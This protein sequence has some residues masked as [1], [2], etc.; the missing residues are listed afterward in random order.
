[1]TTSC[2]SSSTILNSMEPS[3]SPARKPTHIGRSAHKSGLVY[4]IQNKRTSSA[5]PG[6]LYIKPVLAL[7]FHI[8]QVSR[9]PFPTFKMRIR[10]LHGFHY[11]QISRFNRDNTRFGNMMR[12]APF[13]VLWRLDACPSVSL[14]LE[15][16]IWI[17]SSVDS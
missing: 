3:S 8:R 12:H 1:V 16:P 11:T 6:A 14:E 13:S 2:T 10:H 4:R 5:H 15:P 9:E 7:L 17:T